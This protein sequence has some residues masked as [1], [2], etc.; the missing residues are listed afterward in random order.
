MSE[1]FVVVGSGIRPLQVRVAKSD[2][3]GGRGE[4]IWNHHQD[5]ERGQESPE[6]SVQYGEG[7]VTGQAWS[8]K[9]R[10][11]SAMRPLEFNHLHHQRCTNSGGHL[12]SVAQ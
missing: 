2:A 12:L 10:T 4:N 5:E 9:A 8:G 3:I 11:K 6:R 1:R 7:E